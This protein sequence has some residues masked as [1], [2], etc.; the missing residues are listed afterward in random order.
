MVSLKHRFTIGSP[1][2]IN[3]PSHQNL[4]NKASS[5]SFFNFV[6]E[7]RGKFYIALNVV[8]NTNNIKSVFEFYLSS[9]W[10]MFEEEYNKQDY[11][12][13]LFVIIT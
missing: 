2:N 10:F 3:F 6:W 11:V 12:R 7:K 4:P 1:L 5:T 13:I 9:Q 8:A